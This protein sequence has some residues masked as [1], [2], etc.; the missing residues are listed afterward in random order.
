MRTLAFRAS[1]STGFTVVGDHGIG[2]TDAHEGGR[3]KRTRRTCHNFDVGVDLVVSSSGRRTCHCTAPVFGVGGVPVGFTSRRHRGHVGERER[4][5]RGTRQ[6]AQ[7][8]LR[9]SGTENTASTTRRTCRREVAS[10]QGR[11]ENR[12]TSGANVGDRL[13]AQN[14]SVTRTRKQHAGDVHGRRR[15]HVVVDSTAYPSE[16]GKKCGTRQ[17]WCSLGIG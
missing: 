13:H 17:R 7:K 15:R 2:F 9:S 5:R 12:N 10:R 3:H 16:M 4:E 8:I 1:G 11:P 6:R 14:G